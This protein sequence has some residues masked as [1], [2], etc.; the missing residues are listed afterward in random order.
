M[1]RDEDSLRDVYESGQTVLTYAKNVSKEALRSDEMRL[2]AIA[3]KL[4]V[5]EEATTRLSTDF[6][7]AHPEIPW[8]RMIGMRNIMA[9]QYDNI[10]IDILWD[11]IH[12]SVP[13]MLEK[14]EPLVR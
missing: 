10:D 1:Y 14:V 6:R 9:H 8:K 4:L 5:I 2:S 3:Y 7:D 11:V 12:K 13:E